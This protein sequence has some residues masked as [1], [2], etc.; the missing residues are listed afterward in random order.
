MAWEMQWKTGFTGSLTLKDST[1]PLNFGN[2]DENFP[3]CLT[4]A[5]NFDCDK[6]LANGAPQPTPNILPTNELNQTDLKRCSFQH[7]NISG[8]VI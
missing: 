7:L 2:L 4:V 3:G 8:C 5:W 6:R 1:I